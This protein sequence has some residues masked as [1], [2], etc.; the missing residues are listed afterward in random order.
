MK[1]SQIKNILIKNTLIFLLFIPLICINV[2]ANDFELLEDIANISNNQSTTNENNTDIIVTEEYYSDVYKNFEKLIESYGFFMNIDITG[3]STPVYRSSVNNPNKANEYKFVITQ[4]NYANELGF[5]IC[6]ELYKNLFN[7]DPTLAT[8]ERNKDFDI[9]TFFVSDDSYAFIN[10]LRD[11]LGGIKFYSNN[12]SDLN[13]VYINKLD[14]LTAEQQFVTKNIKVNFDFYTQDIPYFNIEPMYKTKTDGYTH[15]HFELT[16]ND[17]F[18]TIFNM[19]ELKSPVLV[20]DFSTLFIISIII[21]SVVF[22][23][24]F[25]KTK[26]K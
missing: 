6:E 22:A 26:E 21:Y 14:T 4:L 18:N 8:L 20:K 17:N 5:N 3:Y 1:F 19:I 2:Y 9:L 25:F 23:I 11:N 16:G 15:Y 10:D 12:N 24:Y 7:S 13:I